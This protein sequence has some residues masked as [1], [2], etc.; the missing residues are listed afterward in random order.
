MPERG[1]HGS[2]RGEARILLDDLQSGR[3]E[4][5]PAVEAA[6]PTA[7]AGKGRFAGIHEAVVGV[8]G[9]LPP[10]VGGLVAQYLKKHVP[11]WAQQLV[12]RLAKLDE[13]YAR[14]I[15]TEIAAEFVQGVRRPAER[16]RILTGR[17][18]VGGIEIDRVGWHGHIQFT[19]E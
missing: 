15:E 13:S 12:D 14:L 19:E 11:T 16:Q 8:G 4:E 18:G 10:L 7:V 5:A 17:L 1:R 9:F 2:G 6:P 3:I